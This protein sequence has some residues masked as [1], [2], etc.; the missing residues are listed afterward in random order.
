MIIIKLRGGLGNQIFQYSAGRRASHINKT[1]L[2]LDTS[3]FKNQK[4]MTKREYLLSCFNIK[5]NFA[6]E[7][8]ITK[9]KSVGKNKLSRCLLR[10]ISFFTPY[11]KRSYI[12]EKYFHFDPSIL[13]I[14]D[15]SYLDGYWASERY[16][17][18]IE[19]IIRKEFTFKLKPD[20]ENKKLIEKIKNSMSVSIHVRRGDYISVNKTH[21]C[22]GVCNS[23]YYKKA[24]KLIAVKVKNPYFFIFSDDPGWVKQNLHLEFPCI[25]VDYNV[26]KKDYE[27][28]RLMSKCRHNIIANSSFSW[29]GAWLNKNKNKVVIVPKRWF[30]DESLN[31]KDLLP[32][33]WIKI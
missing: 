33:D 17:K 7:K 21:G 23:D 18:D 25:Y 24:I 20:S 26:G 1:L 8:E 32:K 6:N 5:E 31:T 9:L 27:D 10:F 19:N 28:M 14:S 29:W 22:H 3:G 4:G 15:N 12:A 30:K 13:N 2:K 11:N 16:F